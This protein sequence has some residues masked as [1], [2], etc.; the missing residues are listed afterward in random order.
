MK[1]LFI[2]DVGEGKCMLLGNAILRGMNM[3]SACTRS[4]KK[5]EQQL[6]VNFGTNKKSI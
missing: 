6:P 2:L 3:K 4:M 1:L 5:E